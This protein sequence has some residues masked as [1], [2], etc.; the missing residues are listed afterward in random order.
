MR[1]IA[2]PSRESR[3][4]T[5]VVI[6]DSTW[7]RTGVNA[8]PSQAKVRMRSRRR[9]PTPPRTR[10]IVRAL[11]ALSASWLLLVALLAGCSTPDEPTVDLLGSARPFLH[12]DTAALVVA[13]IPELTHTAAYKRVEADLLAVDGMSSVVEELHTP[14]DKAVKRVVVAM[15]PAKAREY[16]PHETSLHVVLETSLDDEF[17]LRVMTRPGGEFVTET[18]GDTLMWVRRQ[19]DTP[20]ALTQF[21]DGYLGFGH[22]DAVRAMIKRVAKGSGGLAADSEL[23]AMVGEMPDGVMAWAAVRADAGIADRLPDQAG[24]LSGLRYAVVS[25]TRDAAGDT[26]LS[27]RAIAKSPADAQ[28]IEGKL[29]LLTGLGALSRDLDPD[30][31]DFLASLSLRRDGAVVSLR[32]VLTPEF[33]ATLLDQGD[34]PFL[35]D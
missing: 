9:S 11:L 23:L 8:F 3:W 14:I 33:I 17:L 35:G 24:A 19:G 15:A 18:V 20:V 30:L 12:P 13:N 1:R 31:G 16:R 5:A 28:D 2:S 27:A 29:Q 34:M 26:I 21:A 10:P 32:A 6:L 7:R 4:R 25:G 22:A